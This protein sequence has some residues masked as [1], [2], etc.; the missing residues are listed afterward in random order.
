MPRVRLVLDD[1][2]VAPGDSV[3][4][5]IIGTDAFGG[6]QRL[7]VRLCIDTGFFT[8]RINPFRADSASFRFLL[9]VPG[10][11][12]ENSLVIVEGQV[13]DAQDF[14]VVEQD[15]IVARSAGVTPGPSPRQPSCARPAVG[16]R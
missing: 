7:A 8:A 11:T 16:A 10:D 15:T 13:N 9:P 6:V 4:G 1:S 3:S 5:R 12:P 14:Y 2:V